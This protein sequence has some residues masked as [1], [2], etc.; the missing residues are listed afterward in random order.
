MDCPLCGK[1]LN[2]RKNILYCPNLYCHWVPVRRKNDEIV[3][4]IVDDMEEEQNNA[5]EE[6]DSEQCS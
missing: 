6:L 1:K 5:R 3:Q 2:I 4:N